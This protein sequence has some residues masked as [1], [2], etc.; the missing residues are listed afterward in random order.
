MKEHLHNTKAVVALAQANVTATGNGITLDRQGFYS[1]MFVFAFSAVSANDVSNYLSVLI[2]EGDVSDGSD[3]ATI[4]DTSRII[5]NSYTSPTSD[6]TGATVG[7]I[8]KIGCMTGVK[9]YVRIRLVET[10][11]VDVTGNCIA[12]L[13]HPTHAPVVQ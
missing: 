5:Y 7:G 10:G 1:V 13:G 2:Q 3:M 11:T 6:I 8:F 12:I 9:R 4:S